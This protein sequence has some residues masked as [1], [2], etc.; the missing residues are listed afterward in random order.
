MKVLCEAGT[1]FFSNILLKLIPQTV[2]MAHNFDH[3]L[4]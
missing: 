1:Q 2:K 4:V 3:I